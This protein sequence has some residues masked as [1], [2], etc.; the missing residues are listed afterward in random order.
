MYVIKYSY[1][2]IYSLLSFPNI[3]YIKCR[4]QPQI[5]SYVIII[6]LLPPIQYHTLFSS[7]VASLR[8]IERNKV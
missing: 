6:I 5:L 4:P 7:L 2:A 3:F 8:T 1:T